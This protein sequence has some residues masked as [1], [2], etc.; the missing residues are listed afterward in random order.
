MFEDQ[1][2]RIMAARMLDNASYFAFTAVRENGT[3]ETLSD[4][5]KPPSLPFGWFGLLATVT[6][7]PAVTLLVRWPRQRDPGRSRRGP[8]LVSLSG[9]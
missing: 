4:R 1:I 3:R 5:L 8:S 2:N 9:F 6:Y 7:L